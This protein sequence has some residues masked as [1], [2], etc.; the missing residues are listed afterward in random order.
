MSGHSQDEPQTIKKEIRTYLIIFLALA[1]LTVV[2]VAISYL[3][4]A[5]HLAV[6][7]ALVVATVKAGLVAGFFMHLISER[8]LIYSLLI[9]VVIFFTGLLFLPLGNH[10]D[11]LTGTKDVSWELLASSGTH[12]QAPAENH[13][14]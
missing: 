8:Q 7:L 4:L 5:I 12:D 1:I 13:G 6:V 10:S 3:H 14:N 11:Y 9:F 2:T